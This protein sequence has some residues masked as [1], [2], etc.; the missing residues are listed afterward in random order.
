MR[1]FAFLFC[2]LAAAL[3][4]AAPG[5]IAAEKP[6]PRI[7][8]AIAIEVQNDGAFASD[9]AGNERNELFTKVE[10]EA[11]L[12][13]APGLAL[14]AHGVL[15]PVRDA[16]PG[17]DRYFED[18][19][20]FIEDLWLSYE[21]DW[22][23]IKG[24]KFTPN[25]GVAWDRA[26]G[27][28]G[29]DFAEDGYELS[30]RIGVEGRASFGN[31]TWG[32]HT[33]AASGFFLD[34]SVLA[35]STITGRGT[36]ALADGGVS[37]TNDFS[38]F[39]VSLD[40]SGV[41]GASGPSYHLSYVRQHEGRDGTKTESGIAAALYHEGIKLAPDLSFVPLVEVVHFSNF[42]GID[43]QSRRFVTASGQ[44]NWRN[45][46][47]AVSFTDR[48]TE[49]ADNTTADDHLLQVSG[50]YTFDFGLTA[51]VGWLQTNEENIQTHIIGA[52][53]SYTHEF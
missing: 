13:L 37:N 31:E 21:R 36:L 40:G 17:E 28:Y 32:Q 4:A 25:F 44:L 35:Q 6:S 39:A 30:E 12:H 46:N 1:H 24:G 8:G 48:R 38:S 15:E 41:G 29:T 7:E 50:G 23:A 45:W 20:F 42:G 14:F 47:L 18:Q 5:A 53:L 52:R 51:E 19:G 9:D 27:I 16:A 3:T 34:T 2:L 49:A 11:T 33:L 43:N 22:A 26:P 10:P